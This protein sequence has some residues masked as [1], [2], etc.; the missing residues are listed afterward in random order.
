MRA[1]MRTYLMRLLPLLLLFIAGALPPFAHAAGTASGT[2]IVNQVS[3]ACEVSGIPLPPITA[4]T[5]FLVDRK[6]N[7]AVTA[8]NASYVSSAAG[9]TAQPLAFL[10]TNTGNDVQ[11]FALGAVHSADPYGG[12][13]NFDAANVQVFVESGATAGYQPAQDTATY[14]DE[15][16]A[17][18]GRTVYIVSDIPAGRADGDISALALTATARAGGGAGA[19]GAALT[20][21]AGADTPG[22]VDTVFADPA[23]DTD[24]VRDAAHSDTSAYRV[25]SVNVSLVKSAVVSDP[26]GGGRPQTGATIRYTVSATVSGAGTATAVTVTDPIPANTTYRSGTLRLNGAPLSDAADADSGD[27]GFTA[28][29]ALTVRL[30]DLTSASPAQTVTFEVTI[31]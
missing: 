5:S 27:V 2:A 23:G 30:G 18:T 29:G 21:T 19:P 1:R 7:L 24:V 25:T 22:V 20:E 11:D 14:I 28:P 13:D 8:V 26:F 10:V 16:A 6:I 31:N 17:D 12:T 4:S 3:V 15:L 9:A